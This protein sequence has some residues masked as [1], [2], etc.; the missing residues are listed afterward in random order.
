MLLVREKN[1]NILQIEQVV[2][3]GLQ[4]L[5]AKLIRQCYCEFE[6]CESTLL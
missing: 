4:Y 1:T 6:L 2:N 3:V 5:R